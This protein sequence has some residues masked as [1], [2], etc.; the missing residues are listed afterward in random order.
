MRC[1]RGNKHF[2]IHFWRI[3]S[4]HFPSKDRKDA[5]YEGGNGWKVVYF[6]PNLAFQPLMFYFVR[7]LFP[8]FTLTWRVNSYASR[9]GKGI[10][11][12]NQSI[13]TQ[14]LLILLTIIF[15]WFSLFPTTII[16]TVRS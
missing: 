9:Q 3:R 5:S 10:N 7:V 11:E 8:I 14:L 12:R 16:I 15:S 2:D 13:K 4:I 1:Q 6:P